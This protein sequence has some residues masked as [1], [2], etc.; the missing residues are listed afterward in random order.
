MLI[1][2]IGPGGSGKS[3]TGVALASR[4]GIPCIDLDDEYL[5][6]SDITRD[7]EIYGYEY[8]VHKNIDCYIG[9]S[10]LHD[11]AV[12]VTSSGFMTYS[13]DLHIEVANI[14]ERILASDNTILLLPSFD[15][16]KCIEEIIR[17]QLQKA[18]EAS[19]VAIQKERI[20]ERFPIY[21]PMGNIRIETNRPVDNVVCDIMNKLNL[22]TSKCSGPAKA[23]PLI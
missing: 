20:T 17:R 22:L 1:H 21:S 3:T 14:Q 18:H 13:N 15:K 16:E 7:I 11:H 2:L 19:S 8:Y 6:I 4:L 9:L 23:G 5:K 12:M 10:A